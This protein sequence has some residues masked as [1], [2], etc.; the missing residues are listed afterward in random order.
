LQAR[1]LETDILTFHYVLEGAQGT[2]Y[3]GGFYH[4]VLKFPAEYPFKPPSVLM[5]TPNGRFEVNQRLC[6]SMSDY[7]PESWCAAW[8][9]R[10]SSPPSPP[11]IAV[12]PSTPPPPL[13]AP[14]R[15]PVWSHDKILIGLLSFMSET[16]STAGSINTSDDS[17]RAFAASSLAFNCK[18][19]TFCKLFPELV[20]LQGA[21]A[22]AAR[23]GGGGG[24]GGGAEGAGAA[25][26]GGGG[27]AGEAGE[28]A[29]QG[30]GGWSGVLWAVAALLAAWLAMHLVKAQGAAGVGEF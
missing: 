2:P 9:G 1:P 20:E 22:A 27:G 11:T 8:L 25:A 10:P 26:G 14:R 5:I 17:K 12:P 23:G 4:G 24:G 3:E 18:N 30:G 28:G 13:P 15:N 19:D 16:A 6:F 21:R 7:H 29:R